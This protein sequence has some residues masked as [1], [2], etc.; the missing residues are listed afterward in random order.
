MVDFQARVEVLLYLVG[1]LRLGHSPA[2]PNPVDE[3]S[4]ERIA[5][6]VK[7]LAEPDEVMRQ[8]WLNSCRHSF[9]KMITEKQ[10]RELEDTKAANQVTLAQPDDLIDFYHLKSRKVD[11]KQVFSSTCVFVLPIFCISAR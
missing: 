2:V 4:S 6:C 1:I 7:V 8:V 11:L 10:H 3:D 5:L 9:V